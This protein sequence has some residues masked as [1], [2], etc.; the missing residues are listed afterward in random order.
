M[1]NVECWM[2]PEILYYSFEFGDIFIE[3]YSRNII[4]WFNGFPPYF[5]VIRHPGTALLLSSRSMVIWISCRIALLF[6]HPCEFCFEFDRASA[7][8]HYALIFSFIKTFHI[9]DLT[10][11]GFF[12]FFIRKICIWKPHCIVFY[13][14]ELKN[15]FVI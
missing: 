12:W 11:I 4:V 3:W 7:V 13:I 1:K 9:S 5:S 15:S 2:T 10:L 14:L 6:F 8:A